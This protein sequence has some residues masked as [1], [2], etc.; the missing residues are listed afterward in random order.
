MSSKQ[1]E[2]L[3][4]IR[5][6]FHVMSEITDL[7][8]VDSS[9]SNQIIEDLEQSGYIRRHSLIGAGFYSFYLT[10]KGAS[11]FPELAE[12]D[13]QLQQAGINEKDIELLTFFKENRQYTN[14]Q[15]VSKFPMEVNLLTTHLMKLVRFG[16]LNEIGLW[17]MRVVMSSS[18]DQLLQRLKVI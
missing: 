7:L 11:Q 8:S 2:V 15:L 17:R 12:K 3:I 10:E 14:D 1:N 5:E 9:V 4:Y 6:G 13:L 16:Y 18:G